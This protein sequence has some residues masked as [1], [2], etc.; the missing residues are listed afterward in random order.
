MTVPLSP[1]S[2]FEFLSWLHTGFDINSTVLESLTMGARNLHQVEMM[3]SETTDKVIRDP[4]ET[5][6]DIEGSS[7]LA[8]RDENTEFEDPKVQSKHNSGGFI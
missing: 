7:D 8:E 5:V 6:F 4:A 3:K 1:L 2:G